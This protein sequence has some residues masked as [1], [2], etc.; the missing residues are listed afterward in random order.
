MIPE[1]KRIRMERS[2]CQQ[3]PEK[4]GKLISGGGQVS[5]FVLGVGEGEERDFSEWAKKKPS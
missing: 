4:H 1:T 5:F 3:Q 2:S